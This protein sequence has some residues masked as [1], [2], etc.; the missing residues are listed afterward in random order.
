MVEADP[1]RA[2]SKIVFFNQ[3]GEYLNQLTVGSLPDMLTFTPDG[4]F[5]VAANDNS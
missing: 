2:S 5:L 4:R 3:D 1:K